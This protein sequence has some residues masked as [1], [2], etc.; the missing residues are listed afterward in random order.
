[1]RK[2][3]WLYISSVKLSRVNNPKKAASMKKVT[4]V[5]VDTSM[6]PINVLPNVRGAKHAHRKIPLVKCVAP[7]SKGK[8]SKKG[9]EVSTKLERLKM[10][11]FFGTLESKTNPNEHFTQQKRK[12]WTEVTV[13]K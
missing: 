3:T 10:K 9:R 12:K 4:V 1:M 5:D 6:S 2:M 7:R 11:C 8:V 13:L